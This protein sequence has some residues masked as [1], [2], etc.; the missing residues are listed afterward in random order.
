[1]HSKF[2]EVL[3]YIIIS[4][5][6]VAWF[7][8][9]LTDAATNKMHTIA[10]G[11]ESAVYNSEYAGQPIQMAYRAYLEYAERNDVGHYE[12]LLDIENNIVA[13][14]TDAIVLDREDEIKVAVLEESFD[15]TTVNRIKKDR[16]FDSGIYRWFAVEGVYE[17]DYA[18]LTSFTQRDGN[19]T[20]YTGSHDK[21]G[22]DIANWI[23][24]TIPEAQTILIRNEKLY[25]EAKNAC[26]DYIE[27]IRNGRYEEYHKIDKYI[28]IE[29][30]T[31]PNEE[32]AIVSCSVFHPLSLVLQLYA[33]RLI[34]MVISYVVVI[35]VVAF[36]IKGIKKQ[37]Q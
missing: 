29:Y 9:M 36:F 7:G 16:Y 37:N 11:L 22:E 27:K 26:L 23:V 8:Q 18:Y 32:Y 6:Y 17:G 1:M 19:K 30:T 21:T 14:Y 10:S 25:E 3:I 33:T 35:G 12:V 2:K 24:G 34:V 15:Q 20:T 5:I 31:S 4:L 28:E 13:E